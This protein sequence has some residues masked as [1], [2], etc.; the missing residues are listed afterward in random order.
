VELS[1]RLLGVARCVDGLE[2]RLAMYMGARGDAS[3]G[4]E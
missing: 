3:R 4:R 1:Q 2:G